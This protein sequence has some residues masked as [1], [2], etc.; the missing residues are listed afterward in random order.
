M[1]MVIN[2]LIFIITL[3]FGSPNAEISTQMVQKPVS[4]NI[5]G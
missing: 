3:A 5:A 1:I 2:L 4:I